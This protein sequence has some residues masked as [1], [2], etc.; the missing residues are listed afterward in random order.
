M[1]SGIPA[2]AKKPHPE[3]N[4]Q[5]GGTRKNLQVCIRLTKL[6]FTSW[7]EPM[8]ILSSRR[9]G[10]DEIL[11]AF[12]AKGMGEVQK[13]HHSRLDRIVAIKVPSPPTHS[14]KCKRNRCAGHSVLVRGF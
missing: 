12:G 6:Y 8:A 1:S 13:T 2:E 4:Y 3:R 5:D 7:Q 11:T 14:A 9:L 10:P